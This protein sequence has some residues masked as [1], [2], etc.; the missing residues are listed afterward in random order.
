M[1]ETLI[2]EISR[3]RGAARAAEDHFTAVV[4]A[5]GFQT[6]TYCRRV[7]LA[8]EEAGVPP[9]AM[10]SWGSP[11]IYATWRREVPGVI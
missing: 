8:F 10:I 2:P 1:A 5:E 9:D 11:N 6:F 7:L 3:A 4:P